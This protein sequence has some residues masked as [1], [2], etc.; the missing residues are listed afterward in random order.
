MAHSVKLLPSAQVMIQGA[1]F[2]SGYDLSR[3][4]VSPSPS[5]FTH[6][7]CALSL[8]QINKIFKKLILTMELQ[9]KYMY[10]VDHKS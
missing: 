5:A 2:G 8:S 6:Q 4:P 9:N 1:A 10:S 3:E 7:A